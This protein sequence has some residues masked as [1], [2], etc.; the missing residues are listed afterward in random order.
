M[1]QIRVDIIHVP[2]PVRLAW[3]ATDA[4]SAKLLP[5][6]KM[7]VCVLCGTVLLAVCLVCMSRR[8]GTPEASQDCATAGHSSTTIRPRPRL[9][10]DLVETLKFKTTANFCR[11]IFSLLRSTCCVVANRKKGCHKINGV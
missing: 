8:R 10:T 5:D 9:L 6:E 4:K 11:P 7:L 2:A 1:H 3:A